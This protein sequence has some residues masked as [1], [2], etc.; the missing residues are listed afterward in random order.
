M[1]VRS[2]PPRRLARALVAQDFRDIA[3][4]YETGGLARR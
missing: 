4:G 2:E 1:G 3:L